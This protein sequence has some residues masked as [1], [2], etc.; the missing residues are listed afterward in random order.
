MENKISV[1]GQINATVN[2]AMQQNY[3]PMIRSVTVRNDSEETLRELRLRISFEPEFAQEYTYN[4]PAIAPNA[5]VEI[6][7]VKILLSTRFLFTLTE[8]IVGNITIQVLQ[9]EECLY[10]YHTDIEVLAYDQWS[11]LRMMPELISAFVTPNH[12]RVAE[13]VTKGGEFLKTWTGSPA[14]TGYQT[15]NPDNVKL[16]MAAIYAALRSLGIAY[17]NPPASYEG[18][19]Q[20]IRLPHVVI[21]Q[22][23]GTCLDLSLLYASCLEAVGLYPLI[24]F[25]RGHAY[26]GCRLSEETFA[27]CMVDDISAFEK[28]LVRGS[29]ELLFVECTDFTAGRN[30][31]FDTAL[32]HGRARIEEPAEFEGVVDVQ[33]SRGSGIRPIPL[34]LED[35]NEYLSSGSAEFE[36]LRVKAPKSLELRRMED[37]SSA[38]E[39]ELTK[40]KVW[41]RKLLDFSLRNSLLNFRP[42]RSSLQLMVSELGVLEDALAGGKTL[43]VMEIPSEWTMKMHGVKMHEGETDKELIESIAAQEMKNDRIRTYLPAE[44]LALQLKNM[45]RSAKVSME[46]NGTNTMY[47]ALGFLR[48]FESD[49]SEKPRYAPVVLV[50][51]DIVRNLRSGGYVIRS[52]Q[53][54]A[55]INTTLLEYLRQ[56]F[57]IKI[58]GLETLPEDE[59]GIDLPL[60][61]HTVRQAI[62]S[63]SR[64]NLVD[65]AFIGLFSF[66]QFVM[67][68]DIKN[69]AEELRQNKVVSSLMEGKMNWKTE[70]LSFDASNVES[71]FRPAQLAV[72]LSADS[73]QLV[74]VAAASDG[75]SFVLHGPPGTGK[76]QTITNMIANALYKGKTVLFAAEKMAALSVVQR[77]LAAIGLD[78]FCLELHS[79]K[80]N[81]SVVLSQLNKALEV[82]RIKPPEEHRAAAEKLYALRTSFNDTISALHKKRD[83]GCSVY[84][85][86]ERFEDNAEFKG[87]VSLDRSFTDSFKEEQGEPCRE[88]VRRFALCAK[89]TGPY[90][91]SPW[92][93]CGL[94]EYSLELR[95]DLENDL[96]SAIEVTDRGHKAMETLAGTIGFAERSRMVMAELCDISHALSGEEGKQVFPAVVSSD[97]GEE[98]V[99]RIESVCTSGEEYNRLYAELLRDYDPSVLEYDVNEASG[100]LRQSESGWFLSKSMGV[101]KLVKELR[102]YSN[103]PDFVTK[104]NLAAQYDRIRTVTGL[105]QSLA[106]CSD[107]MTR[108]AGAAFKGVGSDWGFIR[109]TASRSL[110]AKQAIDK[111]DPKRRAKYRECAIYLIKN[112]E[113]REAGAVLSELCRVQDMLNKKYGIDYS[114]PY[115]SGKDYIADYRERLR[116]YSE[117][118]STLKA[119]TSLQEERRRLCALGL[120]SVAA[121]WEKGALEDSELSS[122]FEADLN[123]ALI[124]RTLRSDDVLK[125]FRGSRF[126]DTIEQYREFTE[127]FRMLTIN[128]LVARLSAN[129]PAVSTSG[130][131]SSEIGILKKAIKSNGRMMSIRKLFDQIPNLLRKLCPCMLMS[132]ISVAQYIDP[133]FPKFD[134]VIFDEA[135]QLP[136]SEAVGTIAR[137]DNVIVVGDPNQLPPTNFFSTTKSDEDSME[138][139]DLE[140]LLD[141]CLSISMPQM[142]LKWHY[143]SRHESL[144]AFSN[145][146][147]YDNKLF[148]FPSPNDQRSAVRFVPIEGSYD[149]GRSKQNKAE[150]AAVVEEIIRRLSSGVNE[151]IG[152]VTFSSVQQN[153]IDDMLT[154]AFVKNPDLEEKDRAS[155]EPVFIKNLENVQGDERDVILFSVGYGPDKDGRVSMNFGPLNREGGWRRLNVAVSR[156]RKEMIV[157][158]T[159]RPEQIDLSRTRAQGVAGLKAFLE[160]AQRGR[161]VLAAKAGTAVVTADSLVN[162]IASE[163]EEMGYYVRCNIGC[164]EYRIDLG[165]AS[166]DDPERYLLG[167]M[168]DGSSSIGSTATD[169]FIVQPDVLSGLGWRIMNIWTMEWLDDKNKV[170]ASI[171]EELERCKEASVPENVS[172]AP[173]DHRMEIEKLYEQKDESSQSAGLQ[174]KSYSLNQMGS[175]EDFNSAATDRRIQTAFRRIIDTEAPISRKALYRKVLAAW[176][177]TRLTPKTEARLDSILAKLEVKYTREGDNVF[178]WKTVQDPVAYAIYRTEDSSGNKRTMDE[179]SYYE[180]VNAITEVLEE[181]IGLARKDLVRETAKKFGYSR[182]GTVIEN[183]IE[184]SIDHAMRSSIIADDGSGKLVL[185]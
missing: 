1:S 10:D 110:G 152:V 21:G 9:G 163:I 64:W 33:R 6:E 118:T 23:Q 52:R 86:I 176:N 140:S 95:D 41:E 168:L 39:E 80:T 120:V 128:E 169:R 129:V 22:K 172:A 77:R 29:E 92:K 16:Q 103:S 51:I 76:S 89:E 147:Y 54:E 135:S 2:F 104:D 34:R 182:L 117:N 113:A 36:K 143:R 27:D 26:G 68:N 19:G 115:D 13:V 114:T 142:Y 151:S 122:A 116:L 181:Q 20:R 106:G 11:G 72:P 49:I 44:E 88:A 61:F 78:P 112:G 121:A 17:G 96:R 43:R 161:S 75:R 18:S 90:P 145:M 48:W 32:E 38:N 40:Q 160:Y 70:E 58:N 154:E 132:P 97:N 69:R 164:S 148:T 3:V 109:R 37:L 131:A 155:S 141:D 8:K 79:N 100:R 53:E 42:G 162:R 65:M 127:K 55:R 98:L 136:T 175:Q 28:R 12:P 84:E 138:L 60:I 180:I 125:G 107:E 24:G 99:G 124:L 133:S 63:K 174:Y 31:E 57:S 166:P 183:S 101:S 185:S 134:L 137:G 62:M 178:C 167:I 15:Q 150:A 146:K 74:A 94:A 25:N 105:R 56:I 156:A 119:W 144:I 46:E 173:A 45:Y 7:P 14:F 59:H 149:K 123:F 108:L 111:T 85:A 93:G 179:I 82:G 73:S 126:E 87:I 5:S 67:W 81:K 184:A 30:V 83:Y 130:A 157:Y 177:V 35:T 139:E 66:G 102:A 153:L 91:Q 171:K 4:I 165:V 158:S 159:L 50:P 71:V 47:L 170:L